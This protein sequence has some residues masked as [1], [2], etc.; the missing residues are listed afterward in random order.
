MWYVAPTVERRAVRERCPV[1]DLWS[2]VCAVARCVE[3]LARGEDGP[4]AAVAACSVIDR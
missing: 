4:L 3:M 2:L 1:L